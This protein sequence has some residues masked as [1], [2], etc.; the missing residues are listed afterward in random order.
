M[1]GH[2]NLSTTDNTEQTESL[3]DVGH[4]AKVFII[5][6]ESIEKKCQVVLRLLGGFR[7]FAR[8]KGCHAEAPDAREYTTKRHE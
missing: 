2:V 3:A 5:S 4:S 6:M 7:R 1:K 8:C